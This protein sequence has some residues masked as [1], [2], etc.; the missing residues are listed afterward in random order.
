MGIIHMSVNHMAMKRGHTGRGKH[1]TQSKPRGR[2]VVDFAREQIKALVGVVA[3]Q[4]LLLEYRHLVQDEYG[5]GN[6]EY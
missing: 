5:H 6:D 3:R 1:K 2:Q 4:G